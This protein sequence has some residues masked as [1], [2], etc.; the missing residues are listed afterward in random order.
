M[1]F[2]SYS[3]ESHHLLLGGMGGTFCTLCDT[4]HMQQEHITLYI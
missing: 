2:A 4:V 1:K 3:S